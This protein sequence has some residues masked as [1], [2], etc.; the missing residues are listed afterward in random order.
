MFNFPW[1][2]LLVFM[3]TSTLAA[4]PEQDHRIR[5]KSRNLT[6]NHVQDFAIDQQKVWVR[7]R[8]P[9]TD[10]TEIPFDR[11]EDAAPVEI[12]ADGA[13]LMVRDAGDFIHYKK[14]IDESRS[15]SG[16]YSFTDISLSSHW[17]KNWF[18]FPIV[19][20]FHMPCVNNRLKLPEGVVSWASSHRGDYNHHFED[21]EGR[22]HSV[23]SM[24]TT[25]Y[26]VVNNSSEILF[27]DP[28]LTRGFS[29]RIEGPDPEFVPKQIEASA[30]TIFLLGHVKGKLR[31]YT[32]LADFDT[33]GR[34]PFL[35]GFWS[36]DYTGRDRW[37]RVLL[38]EP[39][40]QSGVL[41]HITIYQTAEMGNDA[42][43][44]RILGTDSSGNLGFYRRKI[45]DGSWWFVKYQHPDEE[46]IRMSVSTRSLSKQESIAD[47]SV[48]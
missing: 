13:N 6:F 34:N 9:A 45:T 39:H 41:P 21:R 48:P 37:N 15:R 40:G 36:E 3:A 4:L 24:V 43:E 5:L 31:L 20:L 46:G 2:A 18:S 27:A 26:A 10:W 32:R 35:P 29:Q 8:K 7:A 11:V 14:V 44:L 12:K 33:I 42:R 22:P 28:Y 25:V 16:E 38:P 17:I 23:F 30:S 47:T 19:S 1:V